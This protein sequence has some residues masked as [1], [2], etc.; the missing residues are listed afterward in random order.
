MSNADV[1]T[2]LLFDHPPDAA[3]GDVAGALA[4]DGWSLK[5]RD[6][7]Y[8]Y[9]VDD[10]YR[11]SAS[12]DHVVADLNETY[13]GSVNVERDGVSVMV[14]RHS[15]LLPTVSTTDILLMAK[16]YDFGTARLSDHTKTRP[17]TSKPTSM[18][19]RPPS[20]PSGR[21]TVSANSTTLSRPSRFRP[22]A[23]C[24]MESSTRCSG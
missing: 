16:R 24:V 9:R 7:E 11:Q 22:T 12:L 1:P 18:V 21:T 8:V 20:T 13:E 2:F 6:D 15:G 17:P 5:R 4:D 19:S 3:L 23:D 10:G 14:S